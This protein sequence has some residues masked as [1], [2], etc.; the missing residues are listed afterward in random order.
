LTKTAPVKSTPEREFKYDVI[1]DWNIIQYFLD[2]KTKDAIL[3]VLQEINNADVRFTICDISIYE[4]QQRIVIGKHKEAH[5]ELIPLPR[6]ALHPE[7]LICAGNLISCYKNHDATK[8]HCNAI[9]LQDTL[10]AA[11]SIQYKTLL[12]TGDYRDYPR[13]FFDEVA[14]WSI[15]RTTGQSIKIYL[16]APDKEQVDAVMRQWNEEPKKAISSSAPKS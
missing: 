12:L 8:P 5:N 14:H 16:L 10:N 13:P 1:L 6:Y 7:V 15:K 3:P 2:K 9:S 4:A 11:T